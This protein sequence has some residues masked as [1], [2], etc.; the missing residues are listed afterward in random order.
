MLQAQVEAGLASI[1]PRPMFA[2]SKVTWQHGKCLGLQARQTNAGRVP[3][4]KGDVY[5]S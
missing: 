1:M 3:E 2:G 5:S 4:Q